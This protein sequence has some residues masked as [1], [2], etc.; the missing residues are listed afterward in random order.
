MNS[1]GE[2]LAKLITYSCIK[3]T[4]A[5]TRIECT[6]LSD[7]RHILHWVRIMVFNATFNNIAVISMWSVLLVEETGIPRESNRPVASHWQTLS[8]SVGPT[9]WNFLLKII[10]IFGIVYCMSVESLGFFLRAKCLKSVMSTLF[11]IYSQLNLQ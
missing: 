10:I 11:I 7:E 4:S 6:H 2:S 5:G 9:Q 3:V 1:W 8:L